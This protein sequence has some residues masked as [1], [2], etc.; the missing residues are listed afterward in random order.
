MKANDI[1][2][3]YGSMGKGDFK[4]C[5][6]GIDYLK[7]DGVQ[8]EINTVKCYNIISEGFLSNNNINA[9]AACIEVCL[10]SDDSSN[11]SLSDDESDE[12]NN[13]LQTVLL[14]FYFDPEFW[15]FLLSPSHELRAVSADSGSRTLV[16]LAF[17]SYEMKIPFSCKIPLGNEID[18]CC[19]PLFASHRKGQGYERLD[20]LTFLTIPY[21]GAEQYRWLLS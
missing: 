16:C 15:E 10:S 7:L 9:T 18:P 17:K 8:Q 6:D 4:I 5:M 2:I 19:D 20:G 1:D 13:C 12:S 21:C 3:Y 14:N 11:E